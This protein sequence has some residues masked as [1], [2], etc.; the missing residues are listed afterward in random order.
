MTIKG[1]VIFYK[2]KV[3]LKPI[4]RILKTKEEAELH[5]EIQTL[6]I[7]H[8]H[9]EK[10]IVELQDLANAL[11]VSIKALKR[12]LIGVEFNGYKK[13][14][15][16]IIKQEKLGELEVKIA[17]LSEPSLSQV[18]SLIENEGITHPYD[19]LSALNY[20]ILWNGL[21]SQKSSICKEKN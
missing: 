11:N 1:E 5:H 3:P 15:E 16:I 13:A 18:V 19:I 21:D 6:N 7:E 9:L 10:D 20:R 14:G 8:L 12:K 2:K 17:S 4:M